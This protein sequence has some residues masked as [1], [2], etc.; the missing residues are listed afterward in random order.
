MS[1]YLPP[2]VARLSMDLGD[3]A[4]K[5]AQ[6]KAMMKGLGGDFK[7]DTSGLTAAATKVTAL[8]KSLQ[9]L[10]GTVRVN[11]DGLGSLAG[12]T[13]AAGAATA[14]ATGLMINGWRLTGNAIHWAIAGGAE[15][16]AVTL[17][18]I[19]ALGAGLAVMSQGA[20]MVQQHMQALS[21]AT[22]ADGQMFGKTAGDVLGLGHA[23]QTAQDAA[24]PA[25]YGILGSALIGVKGHMGELTAAGSQVAQMFQTFAAKLAV[26]FGPGGSLGAKTSSLFAHMTTDLQGLGQV[27]GNV[28]HTVVNIAS[29][30]PGL[31]EFL[32]KGLSG[33]TGFLSGLSG[34]APILI[35][36]G[37][38]FEEL[39]RWG[40]GAAGIL[41]RVGLGLASILKMAGAAEA[42]SKIKGLSTALQDLAKTGL[43]KFQ[44]AGVATLAVGVGF[45]IDKL[46]TARDAA[47][48][49]GDA[50]QRMVMKSS[51]GNV[52]NILLNNIGQLSTHI[53][54]VRQDIN[55]T[56]WDALTKM[57]YQGGRAVL[58]AVQSMG[59]L[60]A[61]MKQQKQEA[62]N[63][64]QGA[65]LIAKTYGTTFVGALALADEANVKLASGIT[66]TSQAAMVARMQIA[67]LVQGY[68]A[69]GQSSGQVGNDMT[70]LAIQSGL[71]ASSVGKLNS[72]W[73]D[74]TSN[75]Q[76]GTGAL[77]T[78]GQ[79]LTSLST[80]TN[81]VFTVLGKA[82]DVSL[83]VK[84]FADA[85][86]SFG[87]SGAIAWQNFNQVISGGQKL[88]DWMRTAGAEGALSA[89]QFTKAGLDMASALVPLASKSAAA[90]A[91]VMGLVHQFDPAIST[92][93]QLKS[94]IQ[95][96]GAS[97][98]GLGGIVSG[99]TAKMADMNSVAQTLGNVLSSALV[100]A[101][102]AAQV[103]AS[104][105]G[106]AMQKYAQDL[107][108]AGTSASQTSGDYANLMSDLEKLGLSASQAASLIAQ[109]TQNLN[110]MPSSKTVT[111]YTNFVTT[112][113]GNI[114]GINPG[115]LP[116]H[117]AGTPAANPGWAWV[118]EAGPELV[119]FKGGETVLP[120]NVSTGYANG[121][122]M[123]GD[124]HIHVYI[125]SR[126]VYGAAQKQ[127]VATQ[128]RTGHNGMQ[129]R[130]R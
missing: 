10:S 66:G 96:S 74:F 51:N 87:G 106:A 47:Q 33:I 53:N 81:K 119:R 125:D 9:G 120:N 20:Q 59:E 97:F 45:L 4:A 91:E 52:M 126:E 16:L 32:L 38:G 29:A 82:K 60:N 27:L 50:L 108:N 22:S 128:R 68:Q 102:Q 37:L 58:Q 36:I 40:G 122:G 98:G 85:L 121:A 64:A 100:S 23:L 84:G 112:G 11:T 12:K 21:T 76:G 28:G 48:R 93:S 7:I 3:F 13:A 115:R 118:G 86:K 109:V 65:A 19:V 34:A 123:P 57:G 130:T 35:T 2:V 107:M 116:G 39:V 110:N 90:Q 49:F 92:F 44:I 75:L 94:A 89:Q 18:A 24:N 83:S 26:E 77:A 55:S 127:S 61:A 17:P 30:M 99:A 114:P 70:A 62:Q 56:N 80:G 15:L 88:L 105:A 101:L 67:S 41:A 6:A 42:A 69:M 25:V 71:A 72:A 1:D 95:Q 63:V 117:A 103:Q 129:R 111:V 79:S 78:L 104:G 46:A 14:A 124:Q 54:Q 43:G 31:A 113:S 8:S 73:D 5:I